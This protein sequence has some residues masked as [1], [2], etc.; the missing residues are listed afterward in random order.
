MFNLLNRRIYIALVLTPMIFLNGNGPVQ[1][2]QKR[3]S[4][5]PYQGRIEI[6]DKWYNFAKI[7]WAKD[8]LRLQNPWKKEVKVAIIDSGLDM[9]HPYFKENVQVTCSE[10]FHSL[11]DEDG[12]GTH[13]A[14][15]IHTLCPQAKIYPLKYFKKVN[16]NA[17]NLD[18]SVRA[19]EYAI[20]ELKV[21]IINYSAGGKKALE[22]ERQL[23]K[24]AKKRGIL[25]VVAAGN[26]R[27]NLDETKNHYPASYNLENMIVVMAH[28]KKLKRAKI[29]N[30]GESSVHVAAPGKYIYSTRPMKLGSYG[31]MSG[32]SQSTAIVSGIAAALMGQFS[33][34]SKTTKGI[35]LRSSVLPPCYHPNCQRK[36]IIEPIKA[37]RLALEEKKL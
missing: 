20:R 8:Y 29:S 17:K 31:N 19:L 4:K 1:N 2:S 30:W 13:I 11:H 21:D 14:G 35:I 33:L 32:T 28:G 7:N 27:Q 23:L 16:C 18:S 36:K 37:W 12:H 25:V 34:D 26:Y 22:K 9:T 15:I 10:K 6:L 5:K 3:E 24:E